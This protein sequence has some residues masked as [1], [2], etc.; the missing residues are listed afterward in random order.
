MWARLV[1][2]LHFVTIR[3][4]AE[5]RLGQKVVGPAITSAPLGVAPFWVRHRCTPSRPLVAAEFM[6]FRPGKLLF[7]QPVLLQARERR[8]ARIA[9][10]RLAPALL[11][12]Q[13]ST[14]VGA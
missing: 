14:A 7:F 10:M 2:L 9:G 6:G 13:V 1:R 8:K 3:A 12:I 4:F 5:R 11:V